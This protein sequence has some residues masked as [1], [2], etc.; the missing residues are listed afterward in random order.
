MGGHQFT[1]ASN[2]ILY[3]TTEGFDLSNYNSTCRA[4]KAFPVGIDSS[5]APL[6][7]KKRNGQ[8]ELLA[9]YAYNNSGLEKCQ[10]YN[11]SSESWQPDLDAEDLPRDFT[12]IHLRNG[13]LLLIGNGKS[14]VYDKNKGFM[15]GFPFPYYPV[16]RGCVLQLSEEEYFFQSNPTYIIN[17]RA[18]TKADFLNWRPP[19]GAPGKFHG[20]QCGLVRDITGKAKSIVSAGGRSVGT[21]TQVLDLDTMTWSD[22]PRLPRN[23]AF[24]TVLP[25]KRSFLIIG[26]WAGH[27]RED[28]Y[29][30]EILE[31]DPNKFDWVVRPEILAN[32]VA[33]PFA[34]LV[35]D[36]L[37]ECE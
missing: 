34:T 36:N 8:E 35:N 11:G 27:Y 2:K 23:V 37:M 4:P 21:L 24:A 29:S 22:G 32:R 26:G 18:N 6:F 3:N 13:S 20:T 16:Q 15:P 30:N 7:I 17:T 31:L 14:F 10:K 33:V 9:C 12:T 1:S 19:T 5:G 28:G 25:Y